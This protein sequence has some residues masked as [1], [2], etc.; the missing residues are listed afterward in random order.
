MVLVAV[1][2]L[3]LVAEAQEQPAPSAPAATEVFIPSYRDPALRSESPDLLGRTSLRFATSDGF[4]PFQAVDATGQPSGFN[5]DLARALCDALQLSCT[6]ET[7]AWE[8][9]PKAL[10]DGRADA[11]IAGLRPTAETRKTLDFTKRYLQLPARFV[12]LA[13]APAEEITPLSLAGKT[14]GVAA[15]SAHEAYIK[16]FFP[17]VRTRSYDRHADGYQW[18][19]SGEASYLFGDGAS[20]ASWLAT[21]EGSCCGFRGG[22]Y[23]DSRYFGEGFAIAVRRGDERLRDALDHALDVTNGNGIFGNIY[24][25]YFP[26]GIY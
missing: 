9:L 19:I 12:A 25:K 18:L 10:A 11:I 16:T 7:F 13:D 26:I 20:L 5:I 2:A 24:L 14:I 6:I 1:L 21:E 4:P 23:I 3:P 8:D 15:G 22:P 17:A